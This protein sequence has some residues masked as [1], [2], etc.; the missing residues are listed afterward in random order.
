MRR[1]ALS[2]RK[3]GPTTEEQSGGGFPFDALIKRISDPSDPTNVSFPFLRLMRRDH[4]IALALHFIMMPIVRAQWYYECSNAQVAAYADKIVRPIWGRLALTIMRHLWAGYSPGVKVFEVIQPD[5]VYETVDGEFKKVWDNGNIGCVVYKPVIPLKPESC[6]PRFKNGNFDGIAYDRRYSDG[7]FL[8]HGEE[9]REIDLLHSFWVTHDQEGEDNS[10]FG[11]SRIAHAAP[12]YH[13]FWYIWT[14][15]GRAFENNADPGPI[16]RYPRDEPSLLNASGDTVKNVETALTI[17]RRRRSGSTTALP[18]EP[19]TD[20]TDRP[21]GSV[22]KWGIEYPEIKTDFEALM[23]WIG[24]LEATKLRA[25]WLPEQGVIEGEGGTSSRNVASEFGS[26]RDESQ[27][28][29]FSQIAEQVDHYLVKPAIKMNFP[30]FEGSIQMKALGFGQY[31]EDTVRQILQLAGQ[32][33]WRSFGIDVQKLVESRGFPM[34]DPIKR[35]RLMDEAAAEVEKNQTPVVE[36]KQGRRAL[37]TQSGFGET[38]YVQLG[39]KIDLAED[40]DFV[41]NLPSTVHFEDKGIVAVARAMRVASRTYFQNVYNDVTR[42]LGRRRDVPEDLDEGRALEVATEILDAWTPRP[43]RSMNFAEMT[44]VHLARAFDRASEI[45]SRN[46]LLGERL[47]SDDVDQAFWLEEHSYEAVARANGDVRDDILS[48]VANELLAGARARDLGEQVRREFA[49]RP[50]SMAEEFTRREVMHAYNRAVLEAG[51]SA[52]LSFAQILDSGDGER[53]RHSHGQ[54]VALPDC[55][56]E[57]G[58]DSS[59]TLGFR[60]LR[61]LDLEVRKAQT[62]GRFKARFDEDTETVLFS[63]DIT[64]EEERGFLLALGERLA[65]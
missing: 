11:F 14:L 47:S 62:D 13:M 20:Y 37:V 30:W 53:C 27:G 17:G 45:Q 46:I 49:R 50:R 25:L 41:A 21:S 28:V 15:L 60:L 16:V 22:F 35:K 7:W 48:F 24:I 2:K 65:A 19:Y 9:K 44:Q 12:I 23:K 33:N 63:P 56:I 32:E 31:D 55:K 58:H 57:A 18:S 4:M 64:R 51:S 1:S 8:I 26:Q 6:R 29:L 42:H 38:H 59:C 34:H 5:W 3:P 52:G 10:I 36:P 43:E 39:G 54:F 61:T 40:G